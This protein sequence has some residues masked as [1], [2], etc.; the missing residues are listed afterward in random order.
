MRGCRMKAMAYFPRFGNER[1]FMIEEKNRIEQSAI[2]PA[3]SEISEEEI[4]RNLIGTFPASD[5]PSWTLGV[6]RNK[7]PKDSDE[8]QRQKKNPPPA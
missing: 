3:S 2:R 7:R 4:D 8:L 6:A 5:P 1:N